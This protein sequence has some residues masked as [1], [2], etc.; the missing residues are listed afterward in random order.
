[1]KTTNSCLVNYLRIY[2]QPK[3]V[4]STVNHVKS[5]R[6]GALILFKPIPGDPSGTTALQLSDKQL[7]NLC[8]I[9]GLNGTGAR[10][11][12]RLVK[13]VGVCKS[14]A[15]I[16]IEPHKKGDTYIGTDKLEHEYTKD[17]VNPTIESI[18]LPEKVTDKLIDAAV[19]EELNWDKIEQ[20]M[21]DLLNGVGAKVNLTA[22]QNSKDAVEEPEPDKIPVDAT[23]AGK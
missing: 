13:F 15:V 21:R 6:Y 16:S 12:N 1:M 2:P 7:D 14:H 17:G 10:T 23:V 4:E 20:S 22:E 9:A 19:E 11:W 18:M 8:Q 3:P 5:L